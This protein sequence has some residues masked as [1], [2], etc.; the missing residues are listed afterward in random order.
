MRGGHRVAGVEVLADPRGTQGHHERVLSVARCGPGEVE[1]VHH[2]ARGRQVGAGEVA[3]AEPLHEVRVRRAGPG[4]GAVRPGQPTVGA[5]GATEAVRRDRVD[6]PETGHPVGAVEKV[7]H[8]HPDPH[9]PADD[10][11]AV[12]PRL[13][14]RAC[15]SSLK[16]RIP[17][18]A[19]IGS[20]SASPT[21]RRSGADPG[22]RWAAP[23]G[24]P[25]RRPRRTRC[26]AAAPARRPRGRRAGRGAQPRRGH[27]L[28]LDPGECHAT[29]SRIRTTVATP[30]RPSSSV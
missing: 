15:R 27:H 28:G 2:P 25:P 19:S 10:V 5:C 7:L 9:A 22:S 16:S 3:F 6:G 8:G 1:R 11:H 30:S 21:P 18:V 12:E 29:S 24:S 14:R 4:P 23:A 20:G 13:S 26:R 17:R